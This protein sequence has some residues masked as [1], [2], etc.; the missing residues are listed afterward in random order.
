[1]RP[2]VSQ[3]I[4]CALTPSQ[5]LARSLVDIPGRPLERQEKLGKKRR[6]EQTNEQN[7][8][9]GRE[10]KVP[11]ER[12]QNEICSMLNIAMTCPSSSRLLQS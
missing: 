9:N 3:P 12:K 6:N 8:R 2:A 7:R 10:G 5:F 1:M 11:G 4:A